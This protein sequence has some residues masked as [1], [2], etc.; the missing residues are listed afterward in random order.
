MTSKHRS[1][2]S[3]SFQQSSIT[4][5]QSSGLSLRGVDARPVDV[6]SIIE[7][8]AGLPRRIIKVHIFGVTWV[9]SN[10][11]VLRGVKLTVRHHVTRD[12]FTRRMWC[13][14]LFGDT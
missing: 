4:F 12:T 13:Y 1:S 10:Q 3:V 9:E 2:R 6:K 11:T 7:I 8:M 14:V 5:R